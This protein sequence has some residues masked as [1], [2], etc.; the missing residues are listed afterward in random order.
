MR[1]HLNRR[2]FLRAASGAAIALPFLESRPARGGGATVPTRLVIFQSGEGNLMPR[3]RPPTLAN[4][5]LELSEMLQPLAAL[6]DKLTVVSGLRNPLPAIHTSNGHNAPG[7]TLLTANVVDTTGNGQFD[8]GIEVAAGHRCLGPSIDHYLASRLGVM[9]PLN[10]AVGSSDPGENRM[11]Y[12]VKDPGDP[13]ANPEAPLNAD[14]V[15]AFNTNLAG[16]PTGTTTRADRFRARRADVLNGVVGSFDELK[17]NL[18]TADKQ[19]VADHLDALRDLQESLNYVPPVECGELTLDVP[20]DFSVPQ[21]PEYAQMDVQASLMV[22]IM[23]GALACGA[24]QIVTLQD[25]QYDGPPFEFLPEGPITGWH[26]QIHNDPSLGLGYGS[27]NDNPTVRAGFL[28]YANVFADLIGRMDQIVEPNG[29]TLLDNSIVL[30]ISEFGMGQSHDPSD[31]P[32]V[33]GGGGQG[34]IQTN[35]HLVRE[36]Y[37]TNDLFTSI[38]HAFDQPDTS[39]GYTGDSSFNKGGVPGLV[40]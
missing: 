33:I 31:L 20:G 14:P 23:V 2:A 37:T 30:W 34:K 7:H 29:L 15:D 1:R 6:K 18:S 24:R 21:W 9:E 40:G 19:R 5:A 38:L 3:F 27:S 17:K 35:R 10:L 22:Q 25:T 13:S 28:H 39:F 36:G 11:F 12:K 4:D 26:A 8:P 16:I 32:V